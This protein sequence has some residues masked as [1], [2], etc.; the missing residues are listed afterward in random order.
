MA[1]NK[2]IEVGGRLH[3]IATGNVLAGADEILDDTTGKKQSEINVET[4]RLV[5]NINES[6]ENLSPEQTEALSVATKANNNE[7]KLG[8]FECLTDGNVASK[9]ITDA[10]GY[11]LSKGGSI[12]IKT[13]NANTASNVTL[14]INSTGAKS[15]YYNGKLASPTNTWENNEIIEVYYDGN[16]Y[17]ANNVSSSGRFSTGEKVKN[18]GIDDEPT[19]GSENLVESGGVYAGLVNK[20][21]IKKNVDIKS[22]LD[23]A[24]IEGNVLVRFARGNIET[25]KFNSKISNTKNILNP[26]EGISDFDLAD[27]NGNVLLRLFN[28]HIQTKKFNSAFVGS[29]SERFVILDTDCN[30]DVD[31]I[32]ALRILCQMEYIGS[33]NILGV[34]IDSRCDDA[35]AG[36]DGFLHYEGIDNMCIGY[37]TTGFQTT[38]NYLSICKQYP[39]HY[40]S[41]N[42]AEDSLD[43]YIRMIDFIPDGM[44]ADIIV[45]GMLTS[46]YR[47]LKY[48]IDNNNLSEWESKIDTIWVMGGKYQS[49]KEWNF[50]HDPVAASYVLSNAPNRINLLDYN[51]G[52][53]VISGGN[54][55]TLG[56][57]WDLCYKC[58]SVSGATAGRQSWD[59]LTVLIACD[60]NPT[61]S[62]I[63][64]IRGTCTVA[65]DGS[66][67]FVQ[68]SVGN[69]YFVSPINLSDWNLGV[70][71]RL[72]QLYL[73][74]YT[75]NRQGLGDT[76]LPRI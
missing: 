27:D 17:Y 19:A 75:H 41:N 6:L 40:Q 16:N 18:V 68:N 64:Y 57:T 61:I 12:K 76:R 26:V 60:N 54:L 34:N 15:L 25:N 72:E 50:E 51:V 66:N 70:K 32:L 4:Y 49:G 8:Y 45:D 46:V 1:E 38:S 10:A 71:Y 55:S 14:N 36:V 7:A 31:D 30:S 35:V 74:P 37:E 48:Y 43:F 5:E 69:H 21:E 56:L 63:S 23:I 33:V 52:N 67:T 22:D 73:R 44:K 42:E 58:L 2:N 65:N 9:T 39:H 3:S 29:S 28:G 11:V 47:A 24:D 20:P 59:P 13:I 53:N 62:G